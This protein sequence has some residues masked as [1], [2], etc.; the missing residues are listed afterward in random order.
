MREMVFDLGAAVRSERPSQGKNMKIQVLNGKDIDV[1]HF[2]LS[3]LA[4]APWEFDAAW[5]A[6]LE[7]GGN[8]CRVDVL[9]IR[10]YR[11]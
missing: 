8:L 3:A 9:G 10:S 2:V 7:L 5:S 1:H 6:P 11:N 4:G